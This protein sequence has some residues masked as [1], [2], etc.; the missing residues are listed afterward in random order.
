MRGCVARDA[1]VKAMEDIVGT[2]KIIAANA[3]SD[4]GLASNQVGSGLMRQYLERRIALGDHRMLTY[5]GQYMACAWQVAYEQR[6]DLAMGLMARALMMIE[7]ISIDQGRCQFAWLLSA[8]PEP[9]LQ[10]ISMNRKRLSIKPYARLAA[11][12]WIAGNLAF[13]KDLDYLESRLKGNKG[14]DRS[15][16]AKE[17]KVEAAPKKTSKGKGK[18][19]DKSKEADGEA[20]G[21]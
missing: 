18:N 4:L 15:D 9:D 8:F 7:Q 2:G 16:D 1:Y 13:L 10:Q 12:P 6:N 21:A 20:Q 5:L 11:A 19:K 17:T 3:A 14:N